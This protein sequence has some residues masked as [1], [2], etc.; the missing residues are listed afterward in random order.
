MK[1][2]VLLLLS[3]CLGVAQANDCDD[4]TYCF[5]WAVWGIVMAILA[6]LCLVF[7]GVFFYFYRRKR[8]RAIEEEN[9]KIEAM[10]SQ[11][12]DETSEGEVVAEPSF[13]EL[14]TPTASKKVELQV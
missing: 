2:T 12:E 11:P 1:T 14:T 9:N 6:G 13:L 8:M 7:F 5:D 10:E 4:G 3:A